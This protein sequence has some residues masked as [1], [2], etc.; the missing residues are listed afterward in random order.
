MHNKKDIK[1]L[2]QVLLDSLDSVSEWDAYN[3]DVINEEVAEVTRLI[4]KMA[5]K[6]HDIEP[7]ASF[8]DA[9]GL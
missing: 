1:L 9:Q 4:G 5:S 6:T 7:Y 2:L 3:D 8:K